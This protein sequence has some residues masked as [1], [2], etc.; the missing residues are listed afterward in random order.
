[1]IEQCVE[2]VACSPPGIRAKILDSSFRRKFSD[3]AKR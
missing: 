3:G 1:L 2:D